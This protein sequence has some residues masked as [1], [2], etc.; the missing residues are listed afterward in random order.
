MGWEMNK[1]SVGDRKSK[2]PLKFVENQINLDSCEGWSMCIPTIRD[3]SL[4][5]FWAIKR[6]DRGGNEE[7]GFS[8]TCGAMCYI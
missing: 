4:F 8:F 7:K 3:V 5:V 6:K 1:E 2:R